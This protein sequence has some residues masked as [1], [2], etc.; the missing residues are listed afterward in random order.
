MS[1]FEDIRKVTSY[2]KP[3]NADGHTIAEVAPGFFLASY[4]ELG[5]GNADAFTKN[6]VEPN[7]G[8]VVNAAPDKCTN[9]TGLY[10]DDI[11]VFCIEGVQDTNDSDAKSHFEEVNAKITSAIESGKGAVL[12]CGQT[13][14]RG[15]VFA[16]AYLMKSQQLTALEATKKIKEKWDPAWP[17]DGFV[18]Q[19]IEYEKELEEK[20][21]TVSL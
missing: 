17:N 20:Q 10:G 7:V 9:R 11:D 8:L 18:R 3:S 6:N 13:I 15:P 14:S 1:S 19:L 5:L 21:T 4:R 16:I 2:D 12:H